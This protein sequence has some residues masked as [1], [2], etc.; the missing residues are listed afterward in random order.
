MNANASSWRDHPTLAHPSFAYLH[1]SGE[2][3][4]GGKEKW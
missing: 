4:K 2:N 1:G 3:F